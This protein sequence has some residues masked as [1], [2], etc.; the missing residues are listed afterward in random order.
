MKKH[1]EDIIKIKIAISLRNL[2]NRNKSIS[3]K[4]DYKKDIVD[5]YE[6]I[7]FIADIRK[8]TVTFAFN[9]ETRTS[10]TTIILIIEAMGYNLN[11]FA[12]VYDNITERDI[13]S[14]KKEYL[15]K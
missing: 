11:D 7:S 4:K 13:E 3:I 14:F 5:S 10:M 12:V 6:K 2:L 9:G 1:T 8:A 15:N